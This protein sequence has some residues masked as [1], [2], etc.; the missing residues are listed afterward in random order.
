[1]GEEMN[2][3]LH[4]YVRAQIILC[5]FMGVCTGL[6]LHLTGVRLYVTL[7]LLAGLGWAVPI[8]GPIIVAVPMALFSLLQVGLRMTL[9]ILLVYAGLNVLDNKILKPKVL[10]GGVR[11][12]PVTVIVALLIG[13]E[14][15]GI[16]GLFIAVPVAAVLRVVFTY[17][18]QRAGIEE[19]PPDVPS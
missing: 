16:I 8:V 4:G 1:M 9:V 6:L 17:V 7:G 15:L 11:L 12:H 2:A 3:L 13:G 14:F 10:G 18:R 19:V 5:V